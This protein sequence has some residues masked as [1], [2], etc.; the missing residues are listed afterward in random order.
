V[1]TRYA[2]RITRYL[3]FNEPNHSDWLRPQKKNGRPLAAHLYRDLANKAI[4]AIRRADP[5]P[6]IVI[7]S[8]APSGSDS[9]SR[10]APTRPLA[11]L[12]AMACVKR[13]LRPMRRGPCRHFKAVSADGFALHPHGIKL[14]P[15]KH[16]RSRDDAP[17]AD[18]SRF[19]RVLDRLTRKRRVRV[20]GGGRFP[21]HLTEFGYQ[22]KPPDP[23]LGVSLRKQARWL[24]RGTERAWGN[25]RV[26]NLTWYVWRDEPGSTSGW[27]SGVYRTNGRRKPALK[28]F[29]FP[30]R[31]STSRIWGQVRPGTTHEV[32][33]E[34]RARRGAYRALRQ[35]STDAY[36]AFTVRMRV[37]RSVRYVRARADG[38]T[39][40]TVRVR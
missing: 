27:Q 6:D 28:A 11:F 37:P 16:A 30:F 19:T 24:S 15:D 14:S 23:Y 9:G 1:A 33:I 25:P 35:V 5:G 22:S 2:G 31:A 34:G 39:S 7:G 26:R 17:L 8:L 18:L 21:L 29:R 12:R 32:T 3:L 13:N 10:N 4:P 40:P 20:T 36:G 38:I